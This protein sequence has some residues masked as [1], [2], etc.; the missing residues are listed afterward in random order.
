MLVDVGQLVSALCWSFF[1][2]L[3][4]FRFINFSSSCWRLRTV[5]YWSADCRV[6]GLQFSCSWSI[7][8]LSVNL[9]N[10]PQFIIFIDFSFF[11]SFL[12][13]HVCQL[14]FLLI[15]LS[16]LHT[17][18]IV[19]TMINRS[20]CK[21]IKQWNLVSL[22]LTHLYLLLSAAVFVTHAACRLSGSSER[23]SDE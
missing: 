18:F 13:R 21:L 17:L 16:L 4:M 22:T 15:C 2:S 3:L 7:F 5:T 19:I 14:L 10:V 8:S 23:L 12:L 20:I 9:L 6:A 11:K 1:M